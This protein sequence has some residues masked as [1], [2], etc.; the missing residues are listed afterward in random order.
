MTTLKEIE[1]DVRRWGWDDITSEDK[2]LLMRAVRQ[3]G[4]AGR[5]YQR[6]VDGEPISDVPEVDLDVLALIG[7]PDED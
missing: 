1:E 7:V 2:E 6:L 3:L 4:Q 5:Y